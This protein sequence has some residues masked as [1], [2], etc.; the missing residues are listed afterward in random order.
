MLRPTL[1]H[2]DLEPVLATRSGAPPI[3][4][5]LDRDH[6]KP[7]DVLE[8][9]AD[10]PPEA[11]VEVER[12]IWA[13]LKPDG[14]LQRSRIGRYIHG[15]GEQRSESLALA[16]LLIV[17]HLLTALTASEG[18]AIVVPEAEPA[19]RAAVGGP[20]ESAGYRTSP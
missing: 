20:L 7:A 16:Q 18:P 19:G 6:G 15:E 9:E 1:P 13:R 2:P 17:Y 10:C 8:I 4:L 5:L 11:A 3:R 12:S 14:R